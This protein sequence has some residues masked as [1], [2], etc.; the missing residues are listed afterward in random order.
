MRANTLCL[1]VNGVMLEEAVDLANFTH[2]LIFVVSCS[3]WRPTDVNIY[4]KVAS[5]KLVTA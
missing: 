3:C 4:L 5:L 1:C 2:G